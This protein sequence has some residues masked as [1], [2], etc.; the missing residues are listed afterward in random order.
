MEQGHPARYWREPKAVMAW[1][2][3]RLLEPASTADL[4][5]A[6]GWPA[7]EVDAVMARLA[8][9]GYARRARARGPGFG[10]RTDGDMRGAV[11]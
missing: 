2:A 10:W 7:P 4:A 6:L 11:R 9:C 3:L 1:T 8:F 5:R